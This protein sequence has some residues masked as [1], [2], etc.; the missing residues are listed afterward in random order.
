M[1]MMGQQLTGQLPFKKVYLHAMVRDKYGRKMSKS[2]GNV[3]DPIHVMEGITLAQLNQTLRS[4]NL[5]PS[6]VEKAV[7]G[8]ELDFPKGIPEC[9]ADALRFGLLAYTSQGRDINLDI[10]RV[11]AYRQFCN[12][13]WNA[14]RFA[15]PNF[16]SLSA[17]EAAVMAKQDTSVLGRAEGHESFADR[18]ILHQLHYTCGALEKAFAAYDFSAGT[19]LVNDFWWDIC[20]YYLEL[21]K[22]VMR[23]DESDPKRKAATAVLYTCL[24][25]GL[26]IMHP[27]MP[28]VTEELYQ[29]LPGRQAA[30]SVASSAFPV[31]PEH[32]CN[33]EVAARFALFK[34]LVHATRSAKVGLGLE[35]N[36][37]PQVAVMCASEAD[38]VLCFLFLLFFFSNSGF[39]PF[40]HSGVV[41]RSGVGHGHA[42]QVRLVQS[43]ARHRRGAAGCCYVAGGQPPGHLALCRAVG[44]R[45]LCRRNRQ[46]A[47]EPGT[48]TLVPIS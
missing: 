33:Q 21:I 45:R 18:W 23:L 11:V 15:L 47:Q 29:R 34:D 8:Q 4:G 41:E 26:R 10:Q 6:E 17:D 48:H 1:V 46:A 39:Q 32:W 28:F 13:L 22:P 7:K 30:D 31:A 44:T 37:R 14:T 35:S 12:K 16:A 43:A 36:A 38:V 19:T 3:L 24:D 5:D 40:H 20:D 2:L 9:G 25:H 42:G 27:F